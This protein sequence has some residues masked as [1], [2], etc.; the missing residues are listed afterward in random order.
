[1]TTTESGEAA[2]RAGAY[3][4]ENLY[5]DVTVDSAGESQLNLNLDFTPSLTVKGGVTSEGE[6]SI[7]IF[8]ER[9]Y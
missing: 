6:T 1:M 5:T 4:N 7:G 2:V 3:L 8:F 9:D